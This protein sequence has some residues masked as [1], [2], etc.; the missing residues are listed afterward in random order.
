MPNLVK[1]YGSEVLKPLLLEGEERLSERERAASMPRVTLNSR[2]LGD[3]LMLGISGFTPLDG[4]MTH[5][6]WKGVCADYR[7]ASGLFWPVPITLSTDE[8][9]AAAIAPGA[10][11]ALVDPS[12]AEPVATMRV[13]EKYSIDKAFECNAVF[14]TADPAHPGVRMVLDQG[15]VNLA[16]PGKLL[17]RGEVPDRYPKL[18]LSHGYT[19][20]RFQ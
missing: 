15:P 19:G 18:F 20:T 11:I 8:V 1:P 5:A 12:A 16:G 17:S 13:L 2:E 3:L 14:R 10:E 9:T 7:L 4:F 6:D